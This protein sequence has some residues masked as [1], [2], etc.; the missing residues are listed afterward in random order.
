MVGALPPKIPLGRLGELPI[1]YLARPEHLPTLSFWRVLHGETSLDAIRDKLIIVGSTREI[2]H[3]VHPTPLGQMAGMV[4]EANGILTLLTQR[5]VKTLPFWGTLPVAVLFVAGILL[6][7]F[8]CRVVHGFLYAAGLTAVSAGVSFFC[9]LQDY[10][11]EVFS[12]LALGVSAWLIG[13]LYKYAQLLAETLR[14]QR[15]AVTDTFTGCLSARYFHLRLNEELKRARLFRRPMALFLIQTTSPAQL[16]QKLSWEELR[17]Q[18]Q[19]WIGM[20]RKMLPSHTLIGR[21]QENRFGILLLR[22]RGSQTQEMTRRIEA[23]LKSVPGLEFSLKLYDPAIHKIP[24]EELPGMPIP[25]DREGDLSA[26][27]SELEEKDKALEKALADLRQA[28]REMEASFLEVTKSLVLALETKDAYTAGHLE[29]VCR[30]ATRLA[31]ELQLPSAEVEAIREAALLHDIGKIGLPD[32]VL[33]KVGAL[34]DEEKQIIQ[35]HLA[36]GAKILEPMKFFRPITTLIYHHHERYDG[37]GYPHGLSGE[38]IPSGAQVITIADSF[39]AMTTHRG[40]NKPKTVQEALE[41]LRRGSGTQFNPLYV[42]KF[43][44]IMGREG[45][46]LAGYE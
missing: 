7:S 5:H 17:K 11:T 37:K 45:P 10:S 39:D 21:L 24:L 26:V 8:Y 35:Q 19:Q 3:D 44:Q 36:I 2:T 34:T 31:Q 23:A 46:R 12:I 41:E 6:F 14:L 18:S 25:V 30:Y 1:N 43:S 15:Q 29:R 32:E 20:L 42:E 33:H 9:A 38:F 40:Y 28:H 22:A 27:S 13:I 16:L 4:I